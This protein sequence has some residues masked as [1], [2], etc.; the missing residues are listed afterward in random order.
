LVVTLT[1]TLGEV[2]RLMAREKVERVFVVETG[3]LPRGLVTQTDV[4]RVLAARM[5]GK[6]SNVSKKS[7]KQL[8]KAHKQVVLELP[9]QFPPPR[10]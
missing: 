7:A 1:T 10:Q 3:M 2:I 8:G 4:C 5:G 9:L 6:D